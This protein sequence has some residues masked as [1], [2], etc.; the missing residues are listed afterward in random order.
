MIYYTK[1]LNGS[2]SVFLDQRCVGHIKAV[3]GGY[4]YFPARSKKGGEVFETVF[5]CKQS[6]EFENELDPFYIN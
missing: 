4:Q 2:I 3:K 1:I 6:L 5:D